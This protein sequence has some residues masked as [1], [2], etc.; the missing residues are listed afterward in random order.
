MAQARQIVAHE[1]GIPVTRQQLYK[2]TI[3]AAGRVIGRIVVACP[4]LKQ[5]VERLHQITRPFIAQQGRV[6]LWF[7]EPFGYRH[8]FLPYGLADGVMF[9]Q[10]ANIEKRHGATI[11]VVKRRRM[12]AIGTPGVAVEIGPKQVVV[13]R[14]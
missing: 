11:V 10:G 12:G 5:D 7:V 9:S 2:I 13:V 14:Q 8:Q 6:A 3:V 1:Q 4:S